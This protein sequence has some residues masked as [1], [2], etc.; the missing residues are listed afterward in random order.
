[1]NLAEL[2]KSFRKIPAIKLVYFFGSRAEG[3]AGPLSDYDFAFYLDEKKAQKR[4]DLKLELF[5]ILGKKLKTDNLD[6]VI[7]NDTEG[8]EL[9]YNII[10]NGKLIY[11]KAPH[12]II[13]EP[14]ILN[15]YFDFI[16]TL[17]KYNLTKA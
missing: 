13:V 11:E 4:F 1:M 14:K 8:P 9:K 6:I 3:K 12:K 16:E 17:R 15:E 5:S 7:L 10:K 2:K